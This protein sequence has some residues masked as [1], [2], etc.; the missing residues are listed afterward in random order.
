[1]ARCLLHRPVFA[2]L[3][4]CSSAVSVDMTD[5]F[6][7]QCIER[8]ITLITIAHDAELAKYHKQILKVSKTDWKLVTQ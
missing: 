4:E 7:T 2:L 8:N 1:M 5:L 6:F 3:D